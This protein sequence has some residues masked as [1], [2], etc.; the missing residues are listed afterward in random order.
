LGSSDV[1]AWRVVRDGEPS[2]VM[3]LDEIEEPVARQGELAVDVEAVGLSVPDL[4]LMRGQYQMKNERPNV[5]GTELGGTVGGGTGL[6]V[7]TRVAATTEA[8][9]LG[10]R[11]VVPDN[12]VMIVP[13]DMSAEVAASLPT[14]YVTAHLALHE[15]AAVRRGEVM[16][17]FGGAG[18]VG[19][20]TV[21]IAK[22]AGA[23]VLATGRGPDRTAACVELGADCAVDTSE[24][25]RVVDA[26]LDFTDGRGADVVIDPVGGDLFDQS[27]RCIA[28]AGRVV[29]VGFTSGT[30]PVLKMNQLIL[31]N[32]AVL[33]VN[34]GLHLEQR[35]E[36]HAKAR[37]DVVALC[38]S[39]RIAPAVHRV[40]DFS[41]APVALQELGDG[42][43]VG[44]AVVRVQERMEERT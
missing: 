2:E 25:S 3:R 35:P 8:G 17:V 13:D 6:A 28:F 30:I 9:A 14:N 23:S 27:R 42:E 12:A 39:G 22:A 24:P 19:S 1:K 4:L 36:I 15:R 33:A 20:A 5:A 11:A 34:N 43:V 44:K 41:E 37:A 26:V 16:V 29:T 38:A 21:Q 18:G 40:Y 32:F 31:R 7:D 10:Q